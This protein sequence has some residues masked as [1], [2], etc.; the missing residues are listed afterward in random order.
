V[1]ELDLNGCVKEFS[2]VHDLKDI[3]VYFTNCDQTY[4]FDVRLG[5]SGSGMAKECIMMIAV[6]IRRI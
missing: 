1:V 5:G 4:G 6:M 3:R 2:A